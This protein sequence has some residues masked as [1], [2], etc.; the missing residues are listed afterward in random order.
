M[1]FEAIKHAVANYEI[2]HR[3]AADMLNKSQSSSSP[4]E[5][6]FWLG[7]AAYEMKEYDLAYDHLLESRRLAPSS[8]VEIRLALCRWRQGHLSEAGD[9]AAS[10]MNQSPDGK[11]RAFCLGTVSNYSSVLGAIEFER[12]N[13]ARA[14]DLVDETIKRDDNDVLAYTVLANSLLLIGDNQAADRALSKALSIANPY[15]RRQLDALREVVHTVVAASGQNR[16]FFVEMG[17]LASRMAC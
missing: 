8:E 11:V 6:E 9:L 10:A 13:S 15:S 17:S 14:R 5:K 3:T 2:V 4:A 1:S 12:G 16:P 7:M